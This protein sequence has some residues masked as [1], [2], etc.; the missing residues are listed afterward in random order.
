MVTKGCVW[1]V[2]IAFT[3]FVV[4]AD[5]ARAEVVSSAPDAAMT[6]GIE[7][8]LSEDD[9][10]T[11][12]GKDTF[13]VRGSLHLAQANSAHDAMREDPAGTRAQSAE[14]AGANPQKREGL[15]AGATIAIVL[16]GVALV[17]LAVAAAASHGSS[18]HVA[19]LNL[20]FGK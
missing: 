16:I 8:S 1:F 15:S 5:Y 4:S 18:G 19:G 7:T 17:G 20:N 11:S 9:G 3:L 14:A 13:S 6:A 2:V 12:G 10:A